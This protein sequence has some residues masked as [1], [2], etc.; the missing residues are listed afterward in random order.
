MVSSGVN[1][2]TPCPYAASAREREPGVGYVR[3]QGAGSG[4]TATS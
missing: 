2:K 3:A 4:L 1:P